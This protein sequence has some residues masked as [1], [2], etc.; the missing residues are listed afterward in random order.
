MSFG[1]EV[2]ASLFHATVVLFFLPSSLQA[3]RPPR[4]GFPGPPFPP[5]FRTI[6][7]TLAMAEKQAT[8]FGLARATEAT[9]A[10]R[11]AC[12]CCAHTE[13]VFVAPPTDVLLE[14]VEKGRK[15]EATGG[16]SR[17]IEGCG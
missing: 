11:I 5:F 7:R 4:P 17:E 12:S 8:P 9:M 13:A 14:S 15:K 1:F 10:R 2:Y 3:G 6:G 16:F